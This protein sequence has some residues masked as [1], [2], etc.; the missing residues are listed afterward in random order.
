MLVVDLWTTEGGVRAG[1]FFNRC[2]NN[3][4]MNQFPGKQYF[5]LLIVGVSDRGAALSHQVLIY[6]AA[7][8]L[9]NLT[10]LL[11]K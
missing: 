11:S 4:E 8:A 5:S 1:C 10:T 9:R 3:L 6:D 2:Y 7:L